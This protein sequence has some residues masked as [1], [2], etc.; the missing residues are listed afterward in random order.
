MF[1]LKTTNMLTGFVTFDP[2]SS[3]ESSAKE[4]FAQYCESKGYDYNLVTLT[5]GGVGHDYR[6]ELVF[7]DSLYAV[8]I[9]RE[10]LIGDS[11]IYFFPYEEKA[12]RF[13]DRAVSEHEYVI[14]PDS[15]DESEAENIVYKDDNMVT[16]Y[17][18]YCSELDSYM[19]NCTTN[20][21]FQKLEGAVHDTHFLLNYGEGYEY[22]LITGTDKDTSA[23]LMKLH[24]E[25]IKLG[26]D[27]EYIIDPEDESTWED[28]KIGTI[29]SKETKYTPEGDVIFCEYYFYF[30]SESSYIR[31]GK[32]NLL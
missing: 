15:L 8:L 19:E 3:V 20:I 10:G 30:G 6:Y 18:G 1:H 16:F 24:D 22:S 7:E 29:Y 4:F 5:A 32:I 11:D 9:L 13:F 17:A 12:R 23:E 14:D 21:I 25:L 26:E 28:E 31:Q 27:L 2:V